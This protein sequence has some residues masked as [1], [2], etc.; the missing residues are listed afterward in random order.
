MPDESCWPH[1]G[2]FSMKLPILVFYAASGW[3]PH[4][5]R[6]QPSGASARPDTPAVHDAAELDV[7]ASPRNHRAATRSAGILPCCPEGVSPSERRARTPSGSRRDGGA[8][9]RHGNVLVLR[10]EAFKWL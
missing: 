9:L 2:R 8:T 4:P 7:A 1:C 3:N 5:K 6:I 10:F